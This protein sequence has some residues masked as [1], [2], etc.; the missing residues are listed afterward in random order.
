MSNIIDSIQLSGVTYT[1][2]GSGGGGIPESAFTAYTAATDSRISED[3]EVTS[4]ALNALDDRL[5]E[6]EEVTAAGLNT[7]NEAVSGKQDTLVSGTNIKTINNESLLGSGNI[8]IQGGS[9][10]VDSS[11]N[12]GST[13]PVQNKVLY[14]E[15]RVPANYTAERTLEWENQDGG[16]TT[17]YPS[18]ASITLEFIV[19][20]SQMTE[21]YFELISN[22]EQGEVGHIYIESTDGSI[23]VSA[24]N[25]TYSISGNVVTATYPTIA[26][27]VDYI[28][29][30]YDCYWT[31]NAYYEQTSILSL[32][33]KVAIN[34]NIITANTSAISALDVRLGEDEEVTAAALNALDD[35]LSEDEEVTSAG[36]NTLN[37]K[38]DGMKLKKLTQAQYDALSGSTD[39]NTLYV[40]VN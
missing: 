38:F 11:L 26:S 13:N 27:T 12:S 14:N 8:D 24:Q 28:Y 15:L 7:L 18:G 4:A 39:S 19:D 30:S 10:T 40:I 21:G 36:L 29:S 23:S 2:Q 16:D 9:I 35:R 37:D 5:S 33:D 22:E 1:I 20:E 25:V 6:D 32:K 31:V 3:E 17:N 34:R